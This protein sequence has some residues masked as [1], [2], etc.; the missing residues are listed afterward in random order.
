MATEPQS[1]RIPPLSANLGQACYKCF[2][3]RSTAEKPISKCSA[4]KRIGYCS[5]G[6]FACIDYPFE[7]LYLFLKNSM[8]KGYSLGPRFQPWVLIYG[9]NP[10]RLV[11]TQAGMQGVANPRRLWVVYVTALLQPFRYHCRR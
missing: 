1:Q 9:Q 4:C 7:S 5:S 11:P 10:E 6:A 3:E 2:V 8:P